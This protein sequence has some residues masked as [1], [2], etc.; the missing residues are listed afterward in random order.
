MICLH[1]THNIGE[2]VQSSSLIQ[3]RRSGLHFLQ[4]T[5]VNADICFLSV[6]KCNRLTQSTAENA[7][8]VNEP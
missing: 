7:A 1:F 4:W 3:I 6:Q 2:G 8:S 5:C